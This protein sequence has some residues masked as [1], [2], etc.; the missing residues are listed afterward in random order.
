VPEVEASCWN[1]G[2]VDGYNDHHHLIMKS[3]RLRNHD[4]HITY[5]LQLLSSVLCTLQSVPV[6]RVCCANI[7]PASKLLVTMDL[8]S[9]A[10]IPSLARSS[11][12]TG[13]PACFSF[14]FRI[15][16]LSVV[17]SASPGSFRCGKVDFHRLYCES[18]HS[19]CRVSFIF[20]HCLKP[21]GVRCELVCSRR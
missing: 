2:H 3:E 18:V 12:N 11:I 16:A 20:S 10:M 7:Q 17:F 4:A 5:T 19:S 1:K 8:S 6:A 9:S 13:H 21:V 14:T 15:C